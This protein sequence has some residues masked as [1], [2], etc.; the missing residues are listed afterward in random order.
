MSCRSGIK[1]AIKEVVPFSKIVD[2]FA[3]EG[4][5]REGNFFVRKANDAL[6]DKLKK[7]FFN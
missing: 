4:E 7:Y 6:R 2:E 5:N 3:I 1:R